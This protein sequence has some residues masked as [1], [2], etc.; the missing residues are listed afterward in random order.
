M[1]VVIIVVVIVTITLG[2]LRVLIQP[3]DEIRS[4]LVTVLVHHQHVRVAWAEALL[5]KMEKLA[6]T[7]RGHDLIDERATRILDPRREAI[8]AVA[9]NDDGGNFL[10]H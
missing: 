2:V 10:E 5:G 8:T 6:F 3:L 4:D 1:M 9:E 7:T